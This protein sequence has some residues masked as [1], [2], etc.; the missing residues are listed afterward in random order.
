MTSISSSTSAF[1]DAAIANMASLSAEAATLQSQVSTGQRLSSGADDPLA[2]SQLRALARSDAL[3]GADSS[4]ADAAKND[5]T[6][7]DDTLSSVAGVVTRIQQLATQ[8]ATATLTD[9]QRA[10]IGKEVAALHDNLVSLANTRDSAGNA[11]FGGATSGAAYTLDAQGNAAYAGSSSAGSLTLGPGLTVTRSL[12]GPEFLNFTSGGKAGDLLALTKALGDA[13]QAPSGAQAAAQAALDP[14]NAA[15]SSITTAQAV[16]GA[17]LSWLDTTATIQT[18]LSQ[19][20]SDAQG[21]IGGA[22]AA[23]AISRLQQTMTALQASQAS[24]AKLASLNLFD[25]IK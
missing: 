9:P 10:A 23:T 19:Q 18:Q 6:Q 11:L 1:S 22:D 2:A 15:T 24:F 21:S 12:T 8:A 14:L 17:R 13:L 7:A 5:L 16:I 25:M 4:A 20:R 3:A